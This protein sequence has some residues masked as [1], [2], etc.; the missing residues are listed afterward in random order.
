MHRVG[1]FGELHY[2]FE[3]WCRPS[4]RRASRANVRWTV[5][6]RLLYHVTPPRD[7]DWF[8]YHF[9]RRRFEMRG[10]SELNLRQKPWLAA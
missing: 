1:K 3:H 10:M 6:E 9:L 4:A 7:R 2:D 5:A 8:F